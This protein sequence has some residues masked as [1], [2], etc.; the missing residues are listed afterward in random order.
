MP[1]LT[2]ILEDIELSSL[3]ESGGAVQ[4]I[5]E[6][7]LIAPAPPSPIQYPR[8][9][10]LAF[11]TVGLVLSIFLAALDSTIIATAIP[12]ITDQFGSIANIAWYGSAYSITNTAFQSSWGKAYGYF[13]LKRVF[14]LAIF[15]FEAGNVICTS[16]Q[17][18]EA[19]ILGR[20]VAGIGG[21][22]LMTGA[23]IIIALTVKPQYRAAYMGVLGV[24]FGCA[25][26]VG[27]LM[28]GA[29]TDGPGW[30]W[31]FWVSLPIGFLATVTMVFFFTSPIPPKE[32][33]LKE[34]VVCM[35]LNGG[36]LVTGAL[37]CFVLAM[38]WAGI[39]SWNSP[40]IIL[41]LAGFGTLSIVF[42]LNER[43]MG[44]KAMIQSHLLRSRRVLTNLIYIFC[45]AGV[46][47]P[48]LYSLPIQFQSINNNSASQSGVRLIP[49]V[50]GVSAFT[51][52]ANALLTY[53]RHY[54]PFLVIGAIAATIGVSMIYTLDMQTSSRVW[55]GYE[56]LTAMGVG[57]ALQIPMIANQAAVS[58]EDMAS[59]TS[60]S[61]FMENVGTSLFV[62]GS[63]AAFTNGL[64]HSLIKKAPTLDANEVLGAG[65]T[66]IR[67]SFTQNEVKI[68]LAS[69]LDGCRVSHVVSVAC[70]AAACLVAIVGVA[71][72]ASQELKRRR[73]KPHEP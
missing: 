18:S 59:A 35:D 38:H 53:W 36:V 11:I 52:V 40:A 56:L 7:T 51:M 70:G 26:V 5:V 57:L 43:F 20:V 62:A 15:V 39:R 41:S 54:N 48:L 42:L 6:S 3:R 32:A 10:K 50:L 60:L 19:L 21:G 30:R 14:L 27:P 45:L 33:T 16:A 8:G 22:G 58:T 9:V 29:L 34:K 68:I 24:T 37:S 73:K 72:T 71:P 66:Q 1:N 44:P 23:F 61:L 28:G 49:L 47:F 55:I 65:V 63:E 46:F 13:D 17:S 12:S 64:L 2:V 67:S 69:Y 31:C 25:S 4:N